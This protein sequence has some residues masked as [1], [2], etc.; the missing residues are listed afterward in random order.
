MAF[1]QYVTNEGPFLSTYH[2]GL[3]IAL[4]STAHQPMVPIGPSVHYSQIRPSERVQFEGP[5]M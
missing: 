1:V 2:L 4:C 3:S 5:N